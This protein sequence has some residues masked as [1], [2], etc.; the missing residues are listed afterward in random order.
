VLYFGCRRAA[1]D[2]LY[3]EELEAAV[4][5]GTL[6]ALRTAF[7]REPGCAKVYVQDVLRQ[8]AAETYTALAQ[9][10][11]YVYVCGGTAMGA[12]V[13]TAIADICVS[14]GGMS[15]DAA[16]AFLQS[17]QKDGRYVQELWS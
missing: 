8:H 10:G 15:S 3:R 12:D 11:A 2:F 6:T 17:L 16:K 9:Q 4:H 14:E 5:A 1:H 13:Q 7:S